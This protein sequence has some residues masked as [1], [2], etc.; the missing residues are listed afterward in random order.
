MG[1]CT[2]TLYKGK[3]CELTECIGDCN[4]KGQCNPLTGLCSCEKGAVG[5]NCFEKSGIYGCKDCKYKTCPNDCNG[6]GQCNRLS[7][8]VHV[9]LIRPRTMTRRRHMLS[10]RLTVACARKASGMASTLL[11]GR[12]LWTR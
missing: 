8:P 1:R 6:K 7:V 11:T 10:E 4:G 2:G 5:G 3:M 12:A 9:Q